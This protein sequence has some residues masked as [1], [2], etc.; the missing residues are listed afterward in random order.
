M[1]ETFESEKH[2]LYV[3]ELCAGG[4]LLT[5]VRARRRLKENVAKYLLKQILDGLYYC[6][7]K[8]ILHRDVKLDNILLN[9]EGKIKVVSL[10]PLDL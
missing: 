8:A 5:Y 7:S 10:L 3:E 6:H 4:D 2:L 1:Y 9:G